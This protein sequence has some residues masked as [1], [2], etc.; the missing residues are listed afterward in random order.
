LFTRIPLVLLLV[1][2]IAGAAPAPAVVSTCIACHG[3]KGE[4]NPA[5]N[6]PALAGQHAAYLERQLRNF[7]AGI[8]GAAAGDTLGTQ[9]RGSAAVLKN[10]AEVT[11]AAKY[12][13]SLPP[14]APRTPGKGDLRNGNNYYQG[15]CGACH[16]GKAEGNPSLS[17]PR[18]AGLDAAYLKRQYQNFQKG[19]RGT[20]AED[21]FGN[22]MKLMSTSL[23]T[24]K[25]LDDVVA[26]I[27]AQ[28]AAR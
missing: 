13:A 28:G 3:A 25:D 10:D 18:L 15:K 4:G 20:H 22:Q 19:L 12:F 1:S 23:P 24:A 17:S 21:K 7:R 16:G 27:H 6:A 11:A 9:M 2:G 5:L 8:R 26:F 14:T